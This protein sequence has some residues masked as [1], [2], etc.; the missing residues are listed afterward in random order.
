M[1]EKGLLFLSCG[2][3]LFFSLLDS[4]LVEA[5]LFFTLHIE[6]SFLLRRKN[7]EGSAWGFFFL[8]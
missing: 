7:E 3:G 1:Y 6:E 2:L 4:P 5:V 8:P